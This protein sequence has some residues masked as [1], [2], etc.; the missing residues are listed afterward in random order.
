MIS[1][2][3]GLCIVT[4]LAAALP[5]AHASAAGVYA[6]TITTNFGTQFN[7]CFTFYGSVTKGTLVTA[8]FGPS[9]P[10]IYT[11]APAPATKYIN[12]VASDAL[13]QA[14]GGSI[15]F[16]GDRMGFQGSRS[17]VAVGSDAYHDSYFLSATQVSSC[18]VEA[19]VS[20]NPY[21]PAG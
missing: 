14:Y 7:D 18:S 13:F 15:S 8:S 3:A 19:P 2:K 10:L 21:K 17:F 16:S 11:A 5:V 1:R 9:Y 4:A 12:A 6:V 20:T